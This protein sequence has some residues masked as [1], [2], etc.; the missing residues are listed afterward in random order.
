[1]IT[2]NSRGTMIRSENILAE[3][4]GRL[5]AECDELEN[6]I[7][8]LEQNLSNTRNKVWVKN[9]GVF[10]YVLLLVSIV[11][12]GISFPIYMNLVTPDKVTHCEIEAE[13]SCRYKIVHRYTL[14]GVVPWH[15]DYE[16][17]QFNSQKEAEKKAEEIGCK[18]GTIAE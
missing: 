8:D 2:T 18:I 12:G 13:T 4:N 15:I 3:D 6:K 5:R 11:L 1:M 9:G 17:G 7:S 10:L 14:I 16:Y